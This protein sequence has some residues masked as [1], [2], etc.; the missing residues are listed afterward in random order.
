[1]NVLIDTNIILDVILQ[2]E[3]WL[4]EAAEVWAS[5]ETGMLHGYLQASVMTDIFYIVR[6]LPYRKFVRIKPLV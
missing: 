2:R 1:M 3:P 4:A 5:C 6:S